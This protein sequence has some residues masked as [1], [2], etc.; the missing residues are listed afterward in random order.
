MNGRAPK[1]P[2][3]PAPGD[4]CGSGCSRCVWDVY[5]DEL[6]S[7]EEYVRDLKAH[8]VEL[9]EDEEEETGS[10]SDEDN[11]EAHDFVGS[12]VIK[13]IDAP[14][15]EDK[16]ITPAVALSSI[17]GHF[18][19]IRDVRLVR[20]SSSQL[21]KDKP[22]QEGQEQAVQIVDVLLDNSCRS[23]EAMTSVVPLPGDVVEVFIPN[24]YDMHNSGYYGEVEKLCDH[25][26]LNP[27]QWCEIHRSP[28]VPPT[29]FP[30]WLPLHCPIQIRMLLA[31]FVDIGSCGYLLRPAF[32]QTL[33]RLAASNQTAQ[34][35]ATTERA[36][37]SMKLLENCASKEVAPFLYR[38]VMNEGSALCYPRLIDMLNVFH[39]VQIPLARL[40]E[41]SGPLRPRRFS[42]TDYTLDD[43]SAVG[44]LRSVQLCLRRVDVSSMTA[45]DAGSGKEDVARTLARHLRAAALHCDTSDSS[46]CN[47]TRPCF[48]KGHVSHPLCTFAS[49]PHSLP[50]YV[51]TKLFGTTLFARSLNAATLPFRTPVAVSA[52]LP[53]LIFVGAGTGIAPFVGAINQLM[54]HR[55]S[56]VEL[57]TRLPNCWVVYGART[58]AELVYHR[59]LQEALRLNAISR[60]DV[61]LSRSSSEGYPKYVTDVLDFHAEELRRAILENNA[62]LFACGPAAALKSLRGRLANH[63]LRLNDDDESVREQRLLLLEKTGQV[64]FDVWAKVNIFE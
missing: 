10:S 57:G 4:C 50:M 64:M 22:S 43:S 60:Y 1:R 37:D 34:P 24:D 33:L 26:K 13:Y 6:A 19:P 28:F 62:R 5:F 29:H 47:M 56:A 8:G 15:N 42:V 20:S 11:G 46:N 23:E 17:L 27:N 51:G 16:V 14:T 44:R 38:K 31:Y 7:Y 40:L 61:A 59:E 54:R 12:V 18:S 63:I 45:D 3:E 39:F 49:Q 55:R 9:D 25:L 32:F 21:V 36:V 48:F 58:F 53:L 35:R 30:P 52:T 2:R 41:V